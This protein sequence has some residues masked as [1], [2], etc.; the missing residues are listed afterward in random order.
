[1]EGIIF[2]NS[3]NLPFYSALTKLLT[4]FLS[5]S[6][7][8]PL[9]KQSFYMTCQI[10]QSICKN[11]LWIC[12]QILSIFKF[13]RPCL[14]VFYAFRDFPKWILTTSCSISRSWWRLSKK[15]SL[16]D[17]RE[18]REVHVTKLRN[19][20]HYFLI[21]GRWHCPNVLQMH[22]TEI[23]LGVLAQLNLYADLVYNKVLMTLENQV[24]V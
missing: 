13:V 10:V 14:H 4:K 12:L 16:E 20:S 24:E 6:I 23:G 3:G 17:S 18:S 1:M 11:K 5:Q 2:I 9:H 8:D 15:V 7:T 21:N 19:F 22:K